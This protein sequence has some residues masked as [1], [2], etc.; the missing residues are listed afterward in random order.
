MPIKAEGSQEIIGEATLRVCLEYGQV[1][2]TVTNGSG[3]NPSGKL[4][5]TVEPYRNIGDEARKALR[6]RCREM[7]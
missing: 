6:G 2:G 7:R 1:E 5:F 3:F 4:P